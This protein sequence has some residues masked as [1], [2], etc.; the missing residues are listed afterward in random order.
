MT[1]LVIDK[2]AL[3]REVIAKAI[4][5]RRPFYMSETAGV[6]EGNVARPFDWYGAPA[7]YQSDCL[8][9]ADA[10]IAGLDAA[11]YRILTIRRVAMPATFC[12]EAEEDEVG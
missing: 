1:G 9:L 7:Y 3:P 4:Y 11:G 6:F 10:A 8:E 2:R 12:I 5:A